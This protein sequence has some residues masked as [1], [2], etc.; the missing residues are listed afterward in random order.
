[1]QIL[2]ANIPRIVAAASRIIVVVVVVIGATTL[3]VETDRSDEW[4]SK[5]ELSIVNDVNV[6][7]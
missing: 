7:K 1:M 4:Q 3:D 2:S 6:M 5:W